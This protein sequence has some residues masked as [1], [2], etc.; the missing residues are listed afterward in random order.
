MEILVKGTV[1]EGTAAEIVNQMRLRNDDQNDYPDTESYIRQLQSNFI[2][3]TGKSC[4]LPKKGAGKA[5]AGVN[6]AFR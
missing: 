2:R 1:Y 6:P 3:S 4:V 5:V